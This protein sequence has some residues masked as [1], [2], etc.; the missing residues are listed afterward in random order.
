[1][2]ERVRSVGMLTLISRILGLLR[3]GVMAAQ[4]GNGVIRDAFTVAFR[5]PNLARQLFGEG[6]LSTAFLPVFIRDREQHGQAAAFRTATAVLI[7]LSSFLFWL[8]LAAEAVILVV[9]Q[10]VE[11]SREA[12]LLLGLT[13]AVLPYLLLVCVLAQTCAIMHGLGR[14]SLPAMFPILLNTLWIGSAIVIWRT[15]ENEVTRIY[16]ISA[17]IVATGVVQLMLSFP[18]L[19]HLGFRLQ[20]SWRENTDR[21]REIR[22]TM[23]PVV[24]GLSITQIN[25]LLDSLVA[26]LL[27]APADLPRSG[28]LPVYPLTEGTA[29]ALYLGQRMYQF[30]LGVFGVALG[31]VIFPL[32]TLHAERNDMTRFRDDLLHGL[33]LVIGIG[34]PAS[35]GLILIAPALTEALFRYGAF[36]DHDS[37]QT[38]GIIMM[39][40][41]GVWASCGLLIINRAFYATGDRQTPLKAGLYSVLVNLTGSLTLVWFLGGRGLAL[42]TAISAAFQCGLAAALLARRRISVAWRSLLGVTCRTAFCTALMVIAV[43]WLVNWLADIPFSTDILRR[44]TRLGSPV[45]VGLAVYLAAARSVGLR[46]PFELLR[47]S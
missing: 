34:I 14:F 30:P 19:K 35:A 33:R 18:A 31:T 8:L 10:M 27:T 39:Y 9:W 2:L 16:L 32:L 24:L 13:A 11:L 28:W 37:R 36:D 47:R 1:M 5:I 29:S 40:G 26:W 25:T 15:V 44:T 4:F 41:L 45:I 43:H 20:T 46:E 22:R 6:A 23:L 7:S 12:S 21:V 3:D 17:S 42:A 38:A